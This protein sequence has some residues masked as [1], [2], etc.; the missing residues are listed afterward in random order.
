MKVARFLKLAIATIAAPYMGVTTTLGGILVVGSFETGWES[1][2]SSVGLLIGV[3]AFA[4][5]IIGLPAMLIL[6][7][8]I[9]WLLVY[10]N[11]PRSFGYVFGGAIVGTLVGAL[12]A[13]IMDDR[14]LTS[15]GPLLGFGAIS[16]GVTAAY[17]WLIR[18]PD[19]D[20]PNPST[21]A[22]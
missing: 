15:H 13:L 5:G 18:R 10:I 6:G 12:F 11:Y 14:S 20:A 3:S 9:H 16:G 8:P 22:P 1:A 17:F 4:G 19:L 7:L 2:A 21:S